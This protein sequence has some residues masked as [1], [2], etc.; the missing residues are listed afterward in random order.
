MRAPELPKVKLAGTVKTDLSNHD[1]TVGLSKI[2]EPTRWGLWPPT[3]ILATSLETTGVKGRPLRKFI[4]PCNCQ[5]PSRALLMPSMPAPNVF[6]LPNGSAYPVLQAKLCGMSKS[7]SAFSQALIPIAG[8]GSCTIVREKEYE[9]M[10]HSPAERRL[11]NLTC[12]AW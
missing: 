2:P 10:N 4:I 11:S 3:P 5:P 12:R 6:P 8:D 7:A 9:P 1:S